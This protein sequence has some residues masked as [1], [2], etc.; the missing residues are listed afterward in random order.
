[1]SHESIVLVRKQHDLANSVDLVLM[2][3]SI[4]VDLS[5]V[6]EVRFIIDDGEGTAKVNSVMTVHPDQSEQG[7]TDRHRREHRQRIERG[8]AR[9]QVVVRRHQEV[10]E[11][12]H[13]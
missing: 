11:Q 13:R 6:V 5:N 9:G 8:H 2:D 3:T 1:M 4:P 12:D 7:G 10:V